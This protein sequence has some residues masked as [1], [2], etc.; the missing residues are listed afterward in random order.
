[1]IV[2]KITRQKTDVMFSPCANLE[3]KVIIFL[4]YA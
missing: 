2:R 1:M 3:S 4:M